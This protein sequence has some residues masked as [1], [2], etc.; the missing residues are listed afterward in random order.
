[1]NVASDTGDL[2]DTLRDA[3]KGIVF[4]GHKNL[5][6]V[7]KLDEEKGIPLACRP[8]KQNHVAV[9]SQ[10]DGVYRFHF[11]P[12]EAVPPSKPARKEA[13]ALYEWMVKLEVDKTVE[14]LSGDSIKPISG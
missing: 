13:L 14:V 5:T 8:E 1:M 6:R 4:D 3:F 9:T 10:P 7:M 12:P 2:V 11:T